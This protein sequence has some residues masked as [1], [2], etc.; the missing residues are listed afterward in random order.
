MVRG[1]R[2]ETLLHR[3][4][5]ELVALFD[6]YHIRATILWIPRR[7]MNDGS[8]K[9]SRQEELEAKDI[10]DPTLADHIFRQLSS[11]YGNFDIENK[12]F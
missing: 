10:E 6:Q 4:V 9:M 8:D 12:N 11:W 3:L 1:S 7:D 5:R 2:I